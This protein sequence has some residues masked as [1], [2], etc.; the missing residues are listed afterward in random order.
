MDQAVLIGHNPNQAVAVA[1]VDQ[2]QLFGIEGQVRQIQDFQ[3]MRFWS[4]GRRS[5]IGHDFR[6]RQIAP[7]QMIC[8]I[9]PNVHGRV[10]QAD[11]EMAPCFEDA[12]H[13]VHPDV[14]AS[15][16]GERRHR[17]FK[18]LAQT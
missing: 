16:I 15:R 3:K 18:R 14:V 1:R 4:A 10:V 6:E 2:R 7:N 5:G 11:F 13:R 17:Q 9:A 12:W 8:A